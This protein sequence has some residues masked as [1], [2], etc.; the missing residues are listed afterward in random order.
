MR[1]EDAI[2]AGPA[3]SEEEIE[4]GATLLS[5]VHDL[6]LTKQAAYAIVG[7]NWATVTFATRSARLLPTAKTGVSGIYRQTHWSDR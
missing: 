2:S 7:A 3:D 4:Q 5:A 6:T 1:D